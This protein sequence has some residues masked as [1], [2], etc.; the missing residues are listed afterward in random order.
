MVSSLTAAGELEDT[1]IIYT[2]DNGFTFG[3]H[4]LSYRKVVPYEES[5]RVP[6]VVRG[7]GFPAGHV[8]RQLVGNIDVAPTIT[9]LSGLDP[10][11]VMDGR[12]FVPFAQDPAVGSERALLLEDWPTG[13]FVG[14]PPHYDAI[15]TSTDV[16][17]EYSTGEREYYDLVDD[18]YQL[19][20][21][22]ADPRTA[23][24]RAALATLI[25]QLK[26]CAGA[27]CEVIGP[28]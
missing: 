25:A 16:Y 9:E 20:S 23:A 4:R 8:A 27:S 21:R 1:V 28:P 7:P 10:G 26:T 19:V 18:P 5:V 13:S 3:E 15:R 12:S 2:S 22:H 11:R 24:R 14:I 17:I 6:L